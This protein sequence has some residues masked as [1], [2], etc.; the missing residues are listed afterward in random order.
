MFSI[1]FICKGPNFKC[2]YCYFS[3]FLMFVCLE[4]WPESHRPI[5]WLLAV[6]WICLVLFVLFSVLLVFGFVCS[7][8]CSVDVRFCLF[9]FLFRSSFVVL[10]C[11]HCYGNCIVI[12]IARFLRSPRFMWINRGSV[13][14]CWLVGWFVRSCVAVAAAVDVDAVGRSEF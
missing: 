6:C 10:V 11:W 8:F 4:T 12:A 7:V 9:C 1:T 2:T 13:L 14:C 5:G 3:V